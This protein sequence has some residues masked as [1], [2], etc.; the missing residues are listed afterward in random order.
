[1]TRTASEAAIVAERTGF[2][3]QFDH[4]LVGQREGFSH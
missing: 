1:L 2:F 3:G 4:E